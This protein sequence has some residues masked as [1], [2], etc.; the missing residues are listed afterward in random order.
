MEVS[1]RGDIAFV[2]AEW[3]RDSLAALVKQKNQMDEDETKEVVDILAEC[4]KDEEIE[5]V[6]QRLVKRTATMEEKEDENDM[7]SKIAAMESENLTGKLT[8][9]GRKKYWTNDD[10]K[11][12]IHS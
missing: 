3:L 1:V 6:L 7:I 5:T 12:I 9:K 11:V 2:D 10:N 4:L 8:T